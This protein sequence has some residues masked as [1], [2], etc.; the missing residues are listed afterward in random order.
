M[1][2]LNIRATAFD[3]FL[4]LYR[5]QAALNGYT[6][7]TIFVFHFPTVNIF[8][9]RFF[10]DVVFSNNIEKMDTKGERKNTRFN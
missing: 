3:T 5:I 8:L 4:T 6:I 2:T 10:K 7:D 1:R 9:Y